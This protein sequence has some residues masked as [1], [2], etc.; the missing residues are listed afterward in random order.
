[1]VRADL[2][3]SLDAGPLLRLEVERAAVEVYDTR[4]W[5]LQLLGDRVLVGPHPSRHLGHS[6]ETAS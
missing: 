3:R 4:E 1:M 2:P 5:L 6:N